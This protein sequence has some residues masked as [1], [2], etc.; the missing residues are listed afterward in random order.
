MCFSIA[1][2][3]FI[4]DELECDAKTSLRFVLSVKHAQQNVASK[5]LTSS[6]SHQSSSETGDTRFIL[7]SQQNIGGNSNEA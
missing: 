7:L 3:K 5:R 6:I 1:D 2:L 4:S